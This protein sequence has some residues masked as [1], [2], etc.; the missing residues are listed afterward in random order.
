MKTVQMRK[1]LAVL[2]AALPACIT[3]SQ[4]R[5]N[6]DLPIV[7][8][9]YELHQALSFNDTGDFYT[10]ADVRFAAPPLGNLRFAKPELPAISRSHVQQGG[11]RYSC[12]QASPKWGD[13]ALGVIQRIP[14]GAELIKAF[15]TYD[16]FSTN[17]TYTE[18]CLFLDVMVPRAVLERAGQG[19]GAPV[20]VWIFGGGYVMGSKTQWGSPAGLLKSSQAQGSDGMIFVAINYRL[21]A[22]GWLSGPS[23]QENGTANAGLYDQRLALEWVQTHISK[24]GGDPNRVTVT[25][26]SAGGASTMYQM[27]AFGGARGPAPFAQAVPQS[28]GVI[29]NVS[30][31]AQE[32]A[33][34]SFLDRLNVSTIQEARG[35]ST[36]MLQ[37][38]NKN[39]VGEH[40]AYGTFTFGPVIDGEFAPGLLPQLFRNGQFDKTV[41]VMA[42]QNSNEGIY[43]TPSSAAQV[44]GFQNY[45]L[46]LFPVMRASNDTV[47]HVFRQLYPP[48]L[49][50][51]VS[52]KA[53]ANLEAVDGNFSTSIA[54]AAWLASDAFIG[55]NRL[56]IHRALNNTY[57]YLFAMGLG[58]HGQ[59]VPYTFFNGESP[60][61]DA[62]TALT[63][64]RYITNF[65][66]SGS[67]N[68][69]DVPHLAS[70]GSN[71][72]MLSFTDVGIHTIT[73][74]FANDRTEWWLRGVFY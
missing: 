23:L 22:F 72:S 66:I 51:T 68:G 9:G 34:R 47:E 41:V 24:F 67:P 53:L 42:G 12:P 32:V 14:H 3:A 54:P 52:N 18:D 61:T 56:S 35:L 8:L 46:D 37:L 6:T 33:A 43:F 63:L 40:S 39:V 15:S 45:A 73:D 31:H 48:E 71:H 30:P 17:A 62:T 70:Y 21:G 59:D 16:G 49:A 4:A 55:V 69:P 5:H 13:D 10:F 28:P 20:M 25:G 2:L 36:D 57:A 64:Q 7:D 58:I 26:E 29:P 1:L 19:Y 38:A 44:S 50:T 11:Q 74:P 27:A 65:V 60:V